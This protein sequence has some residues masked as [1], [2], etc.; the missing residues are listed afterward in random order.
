MPDQVGALIV[1]EKGAHRLTTE[2]LGRGLGAPSFM[3]TPQHPP[4]RQTLLET[5]PLHT[6]E[7]LGQCLLSTMARSPWTP[8]N[9]TGTLAETPCASPIATANVPHPCLWRPPDISEG[10]QWFLDQ[11]RSLHQSDQT[12]ADPAALIKEGLDV[13]KIHRGNCNEDGPQPRHL[14]LIWWPVSYT[15][16]TLPTICSV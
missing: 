7:Y 12:H 6:W 16:L 15:H 4:S 14:Q 2:E 10:S 8:A 1:T 13:L 9:A 3:F 11:V 5:T